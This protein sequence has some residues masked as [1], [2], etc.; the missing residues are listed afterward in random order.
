MT[1]PFAKSSE[2]LE[3]AALL[4]DLQIAICENDEDRADALRDALD[5]PL[6]KL[7][8]DAN[9]WLRGLSGDLDMLCD[10]E[11]FEPNELSTID[12][13]RTLMA[14]W[15][16]VENNPV[17]VLALLRKEQALLPADV[18][19]YFRGRAYHL[20]DMQT[21]GV[22]FLRRAMEI[23]PERV[24]YKVILLNGYW[25]IGNLAQARPLAEG[26]LEDK[27]AVPDEFFLAAGFMLRIIKQVAPSNR[28]ALGK[29]RRQIEAGIRSIPPSAPLPNLA[30]FGFMLLGMISEILN[31]TTQA[32]ESYSRACDLM[33][34]DYAPLLL[35]G[36][37]ALKVDEQKALP[38]FRHA[39]N[40]GAS[41]PLPYLV[42]ARESL[43]AGDYADCQ[44]LCLLVSKLGG[45]MVQGQAYEMMAIA[46]VQMHGETDLA[47]HYLD[48]A[49]KLF[50]SD[51]NIQQNMAVFEQ[52][53]RERLEQEACLP[54]QIA[55][56]QFDMKEESK[57]VQSD[58]LD[59]LLKARISPLWAGSN[60]LNAPLGMAA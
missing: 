52:T 48:E 54:R 16:N 15:Q 47:K 43:R 1:V 39:V 13:H 59:L 49:Y 8:W 3:A 25:A 27:T 37:L 14:A 56:Y 19:A 22:L 21:I 29:L 10:Q 6:N 45:P 9:E 31:R 23:N 50:P 57:S 28:M 34:D 33:P 18:V 36:R 60:P 55:E 26:I 12:Y 40:L 46:E 53:R 44:A 24:P 42:L 2:F 11:V 30:G 7:S 32:R 38:D 58:P 17:A 5:I 51:S 4:V 35:R 41:D 20:L